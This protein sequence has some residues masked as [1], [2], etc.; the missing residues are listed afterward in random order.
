MIRVASGEK[1]LQ[2]K[3][4]KVREGTCPTVEKMSR[5]I[6]SVCARK[7]GSTH[8]RSRRVRAQEIYFERRKVV[9]LLRNRSDQRSAQP[10]GTLKERHEKICRS[11]CFVEDV[12]S[13]DEGDYVFMMDTMHSALDENMFEED[14]NC[15]FKK[16]H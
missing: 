16:W 11:L 5:M 15:C 9:A 14:T 3:Y 10:R 7:P 13:L 6:W 8:A 12:L 4:L 1:W 2:Q